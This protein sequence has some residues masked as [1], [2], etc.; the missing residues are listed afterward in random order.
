MEIENKGNAPQRIEYIDIMKG[1]AI[2]Y[3]VMG[4]VL[5]WTYR[6]WNSAVNNN[7]LGTIA[8]NIIYS[9]HMPLFMFISGLVAFNP[10]KKYS[11]GHVFKRIVQYLVPFVLVGTILFFYRKDPAGIAN[12]WYLRALAEYVIVLYIVETIFSLININVYIKYIYEAVLYVFLF[13]LVIKLLPDNSIL[14]EIICKKHLNLNI[15]FILGWYIRRNTWIQKCILDKDW[16]LP[17]CLIVLFVYVVFDIYKQ[18]LLTFSGVFATYAIA[19][20]LVGSQISNKIMLWGKHTLDIYILHFFFL[21][22]APCIGDF[23][24]TINHLPTAIV[25]QF[26]YA[27][28]VSMFNLF[29]CIALSKIIRKNDI[30]SFIF[31]GKLDLIT[32]YL[33]RK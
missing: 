22:S 26:T 9:F 27:I 19:R 2:F 33:Y 31:F 16:I 5:A 12:Y 30:L 29:I 15:Y 32:N 1:L 14:D 24:L 6:D 10:S 13:G 11:V 8:W 20:L 25:L 23:F 18:T 3:V 17:V 28:V 21:F 4:H 7:F